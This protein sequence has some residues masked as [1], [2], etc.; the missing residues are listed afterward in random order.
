MRESCS[1]V[2]VL[3]C[4]Q[5][6]RVDRTKQYRLGDR[7]SG[8]Q[9]ICGLTLPQRASVE[10]T[11]SIRAL[12]DDCGEEA[13]GLLLTEIH[14][15]RQQR[16]VRGGGLPVD[17]IHE[18]SPKCPLARLRVRQAQE[19]FHVIVSMAELLSQACATCW[20]RKQMHD[21]GSPSWKDHVD[22]SFSSAVRAC[23]K[24]AIHQI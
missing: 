14:L 19:S 24:V 2:F 20:R 21:R 4:E 16:V 15:R 22:I 17:I 12:S 6:R 11:W 18:Q 9:A 23:I 13:G 5:R 10:W 3:L 1:C 8:H 7:K